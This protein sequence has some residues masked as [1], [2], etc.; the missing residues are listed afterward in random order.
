MYFIGGIIVITH[1]V[2]VSWGSSDVHSSDMFAVVLAAFFPLGV[3]RH[4]F[5]RP[6]LKYAY[7]AKMELIELKRHYG[8]ELTE[9]EQVVNSKDFYRGPL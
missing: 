6:L 5:E 2:E 1:F 3:S 4:L 7:K 8:L 9:E